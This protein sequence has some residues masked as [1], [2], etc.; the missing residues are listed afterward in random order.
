VAET[1]PVGA[2]PH[3]HAAQVAVAVVSWNTRD[4]LAKC[5]RSLE[6]PARAGIADV[7]V[8]DNASHDGSPEMVRTDFPWANLIASDVN[9]GFGPAVNR[10]AETAPRPRWLALANADVALEPGA[11]EALLRAGAYDPGAGVL[12]PK[13]VLEDDRPQHSLH[14]F[15][16]VPFTLL[17]NVGL[18]RV[19]Q[20]WGDA[21]CVE[22]CW[23]PDRPRRAPWAVGA[24]LLLR[25]EAW[26]DSGGFDEGQWMYA[27]DLDLGWRMARAGWATRYVPE[28]RVRHAEAAATSQVWGERRV[29]QAQRATYAWM[30]RRRGGIRTRTVAALNVL[31]ARFRWLARAVGARFDRKRWAQTRD[32]FWMWAEAHKTAARDARKIGPP[33]VTEAASS[34]ERV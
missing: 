32:F 24:F 8:F 11:L 23:D 25:R 31:G 15:P 6:A 5:L 4:L 14:S 29:V 3:S 18:H 21:R 2:A 34:S 13:L 12:A 9:L 33:D 7:W 27:E 26:D 19:S 28:A 16:T 30:V 20:A 17:W 22:G 1:S 10:V